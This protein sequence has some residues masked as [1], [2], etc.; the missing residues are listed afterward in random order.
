MNRKDLLSAVSGLLS[1]KLDFLLFAG[2]WLWLGIFQ[3]SELKQ[4]FWG[5]YF[6]ALAVLSVVQIPGLLF[7]WYKPSLK[8]ALDGRRYLLVCLCCFAVFLPLITFCWIALLPEKY[9][10]F[11][12]ISAALSSVTL[13]VLLNADRYYRKR[14]QQISWIKKIK[15][16]NA[17]F[18]SLVLIAVGISAMAVSSM[19][20]PAYETD[21][22]LL[23]GFEFSP[24]KIIR[25]W[26]AF[27]S[28]TAQFLFIYLSGYLFFFINSRV[29]VSK[30]LK[31]KGMLMYLLS[32][33]VTVGFLYPIIG[34]L[35]T[36]L[37]INQ[38]FGRDIFLSN[39]FALEN[40]F[41]AMAIMLISLPVV[42]AIQWATQ[43]GRI[44]S[45]EKEKAQTELDLLKQQLNPHFFF[46]TLNNL[47]A[48]SL[49]RSDKTPESI[50]QL[51]ELMRYVIYKGQEEKVPLIQEVKYIRDYI[52]LQQMRLLKPLNFTFTEEGAGHDHTITPLL[53]IVLVRNN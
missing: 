42:L 24:Y 27:L 14:V 36:L 53:L 47:Y 20:N 9:D 3:V 49:Q 21:K 48:L 51:S 7:V 25:H 23:I 26:L 41:G 8:Q 33:L 43:N 15:F 32:V 39:P 28:F 16:E 37:P 45:L 46:N 35:L 29:L 5:A 4:G 12:I 30:I 11:F 1:R 40:A 38:V 31:Q 2:L 52:E 34:G 50:L 6:S 18:I 22:Q 44:I 17:V 19:G 13:E 10:A